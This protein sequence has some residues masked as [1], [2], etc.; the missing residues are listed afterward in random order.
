MT[1]PNHIT[2]FID[3]LRDSLEKGIFS[4][5][6]M[7]KYHGPEPNLIKYII[8]LVEIKKQKYLSFVRHYQKKDITE[9]FPVIKG[10]EE[11]TKLLGVTF[12]RAHLI[13]M[14]GSAQLEFSRK[15]KCRLTHGK[16]TGSVVRSSEHDREKQRIIDHRRPFLHELGITNNFGQVLPSMSCKW[17]QINK[18]ME[19]FNHAVVSSELSSRP[20]I[21]VVD[22]GCGKGYLTFAM[23]D[24]LCN[25]LAVA[26]NVTGVELREN[27]VRF[28]NDTSAK[29]A[30]A[31]L[32]FCQGNVEN[33]TPAKIDAL[34]ALHACDTATDLAINMGVH[35]GAT[36]IMCAPCCHKQIRPQIKTPEVLKPILR[37]GSHL[38]QE[39]DM[40]TDGLRALLLETQGYKASVFEFISLEHTDKNKMI[41]GVKC[42]GKIDPNPIWLQINAIKDFYGIREHKLESL[43]KS[44]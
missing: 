36:I 11:I 14:D 17:K 43:L 13:T 44:E 15:G 26:A 9:N 20:G 35:A 29:L 31:G 7:A 38:A 32:H 1:S 42:P 4:Q 22:F 41:L 8:R 10:V 3:G 33:Y 25:T 37:F 39:A 28:C 40:I 30:C 27:L 34:I 19:F 21:D 2:K 18:F 6:V 24:F 5:L 12:M 16:S 23:H